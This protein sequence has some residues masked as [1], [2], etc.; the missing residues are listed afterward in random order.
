MKMSTNEH[1][2]TQVC[3]FMV[4]KNYKKAMFYNISHCGS[5]LRPAFLRFSDNL[6]FDQIPTTV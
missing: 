5:L 1:F 4:Q 3:R 6:R 2:K